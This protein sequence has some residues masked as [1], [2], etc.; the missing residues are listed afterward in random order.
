MGGLW[1]AL[2]SFSKFAEK[3]L[4]KMQEQIERMNEQAEKREEKRQ[5]AYQ[6]KQVIIDEFK[7]QFYSLSDKELVDIIHSNEMNLAKSAALDILKERGY[8]PDSDNVWR[9]K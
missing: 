8:E 5:Q 2:N 6:D 4:P 9:K 1:N 3:N 7:S